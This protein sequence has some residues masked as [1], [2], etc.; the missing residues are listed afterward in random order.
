LLTPPTS[1]T[2]G[3]AVVVDYNINVNVNT[4]TT[5]REHTIALKQIPIYYKCLIMVE[6][7]LNQTVSRKISGAQPTKNLLFK[8]L[9]K[10]Y[11]I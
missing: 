10:Q 6:H 11:H 8:L 3:Q 5:Q 9:Y 2:G 7:T 1:L 4:D